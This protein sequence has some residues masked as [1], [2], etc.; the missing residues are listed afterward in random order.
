MAQQIADAVIEVDKNTSLGVLISTS[1]DPEN[2]YTVESDLIFM[3]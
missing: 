1:N 3:E 2:G